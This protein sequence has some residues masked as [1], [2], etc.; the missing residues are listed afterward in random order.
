MVSAVAAP[1][2]RLAPVTTANRPESQCLD[3]TMDR[4]SGTSA[5]DSPVEPFMSLEA[6][7]R[8]PA[9]VRHARGIPYATVPTPS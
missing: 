1:I 5:D 3:S 2:P 7:A 9:G 8:D 4:G 6:S